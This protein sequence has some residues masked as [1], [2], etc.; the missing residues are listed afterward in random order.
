MCRLLLANRDLFIKAPLHLGSPT[1][2]PCAC[3]PHAPHERPHSAQRRVA[4]CST[5]PQ[6]ERRGSEKVPSLPLTWHLKGGP[7]KRN[8]I[9]QVPSHRCHVCWRE[10]NLFCNTKA[11]DAHDHFITLMH[12]KKLASFPQPR[13]ECPRSSKHLS[14]QNHGSFFGPWCCLVPLVKGDA[15]KGP[16]EFDNPPSA[17]RP[18]MTEMLIPSV[19]M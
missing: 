19:F 11:V 17:F 15:K 9:F 12:H 3:A 6:P 2:F 5:K 1:L 14:C 4:L 16:P 8:L 7:S 13:G 10:G 18:K